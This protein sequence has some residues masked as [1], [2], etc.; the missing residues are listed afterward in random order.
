MKLAE[1]L[2]ERKGAKDRIDSLRERIKSAALVQE[3]DTPTERPEEL[4]KE[5]T[6]AVEQLGELIRAINRTNNVARLPDET[7]LSEAIVKRD[8][9]RL[10]R[11]ALEQVVESSSTLDHFRYSRNEVKF[12]AT[13][14]IASVRN[15]IDRLA[16]EWREMDAQIQATNWMTDV[17]GFD[18]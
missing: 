15:S 13:L 9:L 16:K 4:L 5:L 17:D 6:L 10:Q 14:D 18:N 2:L 7:T 11:Q 3:G 1:A 12:V 8:M